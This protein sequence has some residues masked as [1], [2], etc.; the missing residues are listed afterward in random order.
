MQERNIV[1]RYFY[2]WEDN[3]L[4]ADIIGIN[5]FSTYHIRDTIQSIQTFSFLY[6]EFSI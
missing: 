5:V 2:L 1:F 4:Y 3:V 6:I